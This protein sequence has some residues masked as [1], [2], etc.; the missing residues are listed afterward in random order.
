MFGVGRTEEWGRTHHKGRTQI[1]LASDSC[2]RPHN[3]FH[4]TL[5]TITQCR[6]RY[7]CVRKRRP[8]IVFASITANPDGV[9]CICTLTYTRTVSSH[10]ARR[11][12]SCGVF[13]VDDGSL[14]RLRLAEPYA[15]EPIFQQAVNENDV[16]K[17]LPRIVAAD[18]ALSDRQKEIAGAPHRFE[19]D[20]E[21]KA[22]LVAADALL[23]LKAEKLGWPTVS[24]TQPKRQERAD[25]SVSVSSK[26]SE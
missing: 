1:D 24:A 13:S 12:F 15:W 17:I 23:K 6:Q 18:E 2:F 8:P 5:N 14:R 19:V 4:A 11:L 7:G 26:Q 10:I 3:D 9:A 22:M 16:S 20:A 21:L 25:S